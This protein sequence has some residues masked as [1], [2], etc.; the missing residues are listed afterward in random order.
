MPPTPRKHWIRGLCL[1]TLA[2]LALSQT[3]CIAAAVVGGV[4]AAGAGG[5]A[6]YAADVPRDYPA[7]MDVTWA[8]TQQS[9]AELGMSVEKAERDNDSAVL[10]THTGDG[11]KV[12]IRLEP[13][14]SRVP[15]DGQWTH[16]T[17]KVGWL[18]DDDLSERV[19]KQIETHVPHAAPPP[20]VPVVQPGAPAGQPGPLVPVVETQA[21]P[22]AKER[23]F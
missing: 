1:A 3:G 9:V 7:T 12:R 15:A 16:V 20:G 14:A 11:T 6:L 13:R 22:L 23:G 4:A 17:V 19:F 5:Y 18:G 10:E 21:P 2:A 8:A